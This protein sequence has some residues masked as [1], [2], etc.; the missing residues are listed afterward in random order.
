MYEREFLQYA[1]TCLYALQIVATH[2]RCLEVKVVLSRS[3]W[4]LLYTQA[5]IPLSYLRVA[6]KNIA[7]RASVRLPL[8]KKRVHNN[9]S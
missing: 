8:I 4:A 2:A 1:S 6:A 9:N 3:L 5:Q 7:M